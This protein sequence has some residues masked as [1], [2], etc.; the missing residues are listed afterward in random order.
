MKKA[1]TALRK[2]HAF[3]GI[4]IAMLLI[5]LSFH[6]VIFSGASIRVTD[7]LNGTFN[8]MRSSA[9]FP[10][11]GHT[12]WWSGQADSGGA[13][14]QSEPMAEFVKST[15]WSGESLYWNPFSGAGALGPETL[16][17]LKLSLFTLLY[18][19]V[20][21]GSLAYNIIFLAGYFV[22]IV[23][24]YMCA[25]TYLGISKLGAIGTCIFFLLN[26]YSTAS[27]GSNVTLSYPLAPFLL[28]AT[29][30]VLTRTTAGTVSIFALALAAIMSFTFLPT[31]ITTLI[32]VGVIAGTYL[33]TKLIRGNNLLKSTAQSVWPALLGVVIAALIV[34]PIYIP[35]IESL[36]FTGTLDEYSKR[37]FHAIFFPQA[38]TSFFSPSLFF[39]SYNAMENKA[40][41][42]YN[43]LGSFPGNTVYH[44]GLMG[45]LLSAAAIPKRG[46]IGL[47]SITC[48]L[49]V[50]VTLARLFNP[51]VFDYVFSKIP[52]VRN[53]GYQYWWPC[54]VIPL[55]FLVGCGID[56]IRNN[57]ARIFPIAA[58]LGVFSTAVIYMWWTYGLGEPVLAYKRAVLF[59]MFGAVAVFIALFVLTRVGTSKTRNVATIALV[60]VMFGE[61]AV[62]SKV[63][64][65][66]RSD[67]FSSPPSA[68][69][70]V[71]DNVGLYRT[72]NFGQTGLYPELSSAF[73][74]QEIS[75]MNSAT[76][77][78]YLD[79]FYSAVNLAPTQRFGVSKTY[80][81]GAFP[82]LYLSKDEPSTNQ[83]DL[84]KLR[85]LGVKYVLLPSEYKRYKEWFIERGFHVAFEST[86]TVV[87]ETP[88]T[89]PRA[90]FVPVE[91]KLNDGDLTL[92]DDF[93][94]TLQP[95]TITAYHN[96][97][98]TLE[99][100][101]DQDGVVILTDTWH[102]WWE[103]TVNGVGTQ[104]VLHVESAFRGV[105]VPK[106]NY[107]I[108]LSYQPWSQIIA[109]IL[110]AMGIGFIISLLIFRK[111][112]N[113]TLIAKKASSD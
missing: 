58:A 87:L 81:R 95:T 25:R 48:F 80:P 59:G 75:S 37:I 11:P 51:G 69:Q 79:F 77:A 60:L 82:T 108:L 88:R 50:L 6:D 86:V 52:I 113:R 2:S 55:S 16:V 68:I 107:E 90:F 110:C 17:D 91:S 63:V 72:L 65:L 10:V 97:W 101:A 94:H 74:I 67:I 42:Y 103:A 7:Q 61:L 21:G 26:G 47:C 15:F 18:S 109:K 32:V 84:E 43:E 85:L 56:N 22:G 99:G 73:G 112:I 96:T 106:G 66:P 92:P 8:R 100:H 19:L 29:F 34:S 64:R 89:L 23:S 38:L 41:Y 78:A 24:L 44:L 20:G 13:A 104:P 12:E 54:V 83:I 70:F 40:I 49:I 3:S 39:E 105:R 76:M 1:L 71:K 62:D 4:L 45:I 33:A 46:K 93:E 30:S 14:F 98:V 111:K 35:L 27:L 9:P 36:K 28:L 31:T 57:N 102:P 5:I 53:I